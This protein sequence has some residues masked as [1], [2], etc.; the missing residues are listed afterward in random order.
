[1]ASAGDTS[2]ACTLTVKA[3]E[4]AS[5]VP[6]SDFTAS[7][8]VGDSETAKALGAFADKGLSL[9]VQ[10]LETL[11]VAT[12]EAL[13]ALRTAGL[14]VAETLDI[15]FSTADQERITVNA[16]GDSALSITV[17]IKLTE[18]MRELDLT[19]LLVSFVGDDGTVEEKVTWIDGEYLCFKTSHFSTYVVTGRPRTVQD[20]AIETG[21]P[22]D[23]D[24][25]VKAIALAP[26][27][28]DTARFAGAIALAAL[29]AAGVAG[30]VRKRAR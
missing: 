27:G 6:G 30:A 17:R 14:T 18:A 20:S 19:S 25:T 4:M 13:N 26:T 16:D 1:M 22:T 5:T 23:S 3:K 2:A 12:Q 11:P 9:S 21:A 8:E 29:A 28:D 15:H 24:R 10:R 7:V